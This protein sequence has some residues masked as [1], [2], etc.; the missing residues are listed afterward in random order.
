M[1]GNV[2][3]VQTQTLHINHGHVLYSVESVNKKRTQVLKN[4]DK[5]VQVQPLGSFVIS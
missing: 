3:L 5:K 1:K 4:K 2:K